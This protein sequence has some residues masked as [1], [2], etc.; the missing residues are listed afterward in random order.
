MNYNN[1]TKYYVKGSNN[2]KLYLSDET[3]KILYKFNQVKRIVN[4]V[5]TQNTFKND[6][7][8]PYTNEKD[9]IV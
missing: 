9:K 8:V 4:V 7:E 1:R 6:F 5:S 2:Q 3:N